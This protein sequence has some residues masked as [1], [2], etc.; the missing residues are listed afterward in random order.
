MRKPLK[1]AAPR[2]LHPLS[3]VDHAKVNFNAG[4]STSYIYV[5]YAGTASGTLSMSGTTSIA[6]TTGDAGSATYATGIL[7]GYNYPVKGLIT[8]TD[9]AGDFPLT[10]RSPRQPFSP[11]IIYVGE[12]ARGRARSA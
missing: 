11:R 2:R 4:T 10:P 12:A 7:A 1:H 9:H 3:M 6:M 8:M 5:G